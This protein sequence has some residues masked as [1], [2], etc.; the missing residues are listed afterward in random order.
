M[1]YRYPHRQPENDA[2][3]TLPL[4][5]KPR[6]VISFSSFVFSSFVKINYLCD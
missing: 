1:S 2:T 5:H 3:L 6:F 4:S